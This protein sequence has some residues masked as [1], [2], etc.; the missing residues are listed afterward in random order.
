[1]ERNKILHF[2]IWSSP[3][4]SQS[5]ENLLRDTFPEYDLE[6][7]TL[8]DSIKT[9]KRMLAAN[10]FSVLKEYGLEI[11]SGR[12]NFKAAFF[13]T[14][15]LFDCVRRMAE[16]IGRSRQDVAFTFQLQSIFD[17]H[18]EGIPN[19]IYT[20]HTHLANLLYSP[21]MKVNLY[22]AEWISRENTI[23]NNAQAVFTRSS[24]ISRSVT[25]QYGVPAEKVR[26]IF[27]GANTP[28][29]G[30]AP[31][32]KDYSAKS[33]LFVGL[34]WVR[35]GGPD[36][37]RAFEQ[38]HKKHPDATLTIVG[39]PV[40][41]DLPGVVCTGRVSVE[42]L[43]R[44]YQKATVF[45]MPS[46]S[47]PFGVVFVE[48]MS[49]ALP[50]VAAKIGALADMVSEGENGF[51][52]EPGDVNG[53]V[54]ALDVLLSDAQLRARFGKKSWQAAHE[55]YNWGAVGILLRKYVKEYLRGQNR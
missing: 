38:I 55:R 7:I 14:V 36:L 42:E 9:D 23:Y 34:D 37:L 22:S 21:L 24:N 35:K 11:L 12:L 48:A 1:L 43:N 44:Y 8:W 27:A 39:S 6:T 10:A 45:C 32:K 13:R 5:V 52:I 18:L 47:E 4:I 41:T 16:E 46:R 19:F 25:E 26:C 54:G 30:L 33:I 29:A 53:L 17:T 49:H 40:K 31:K 15:Y 50:V 2:R 20:D 28:L 51:L 3:P